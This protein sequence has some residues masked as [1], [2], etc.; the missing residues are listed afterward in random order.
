MRLKYPASKAKAGAT[1]GGSC[2]NGS[3]GEELM[4][5]PLEQIAQ[6]FHSPGAEA[7]MPSVVVAAA[8]AATAAASTASAAG[9]ESTAS[10]SA[11]ASTA[12]W[13]VAHMRVAT[14]V[15]EPSLTKRLTMLLLA[16]LRASGTFRLFV[17]GSGDRRREFYSNLGFS[18][19]A[20]AGVGSAAGDNVA[21]GRDETSY[22]NRSF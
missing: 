21:G 13:G 17:D 8:A 20:S 15:T 9:S 4:L 19:M 16:S 3:T 5:T 10:A 12:P 7:T 2:E 22:M 1:I 14:S 11:A 18:P 6:S